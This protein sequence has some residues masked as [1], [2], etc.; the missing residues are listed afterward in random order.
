ML[1]GCGIVSVV[2]AR[3][4]VRGVEVLVLVIET[5][6]VA[7]LLAHHQV[8]PCS[9]VVLCG[10]EVRIVDLGSALRDVLAADPDLGDAKP[11][12]VAVGTVADLY[13][14]TGRT[15]VLR[16]SLP[17]DDPSVKHRGLRA[18]ANRRV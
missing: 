5:E 14:S 18:C 9:G 4:E 15:A 11:A 17:G 7:D 1:V 3:P 16:L 8:P 2:H 12:V 6:G 13:P 10:V